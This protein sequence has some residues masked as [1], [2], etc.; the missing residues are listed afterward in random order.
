MS[1]EGDRQEPTGAAESGHAN[2]A[3]V[4]VEA[5]ESV[6]ADDPFDETAAVAR[7]GQAGALPRV[8]LAV[9]LKVAVVN[10]DVALS[11][12]NAAKG[13]NLGHCDGEGDGPDFSG[14]SGRSDR[15]DVES[16]L[17]FARHTGLTR[18]MIRAWETSLSYWCSLR[19]SS[20][21]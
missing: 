6:R 3:A 5:L 15:E 21:L 9:T 1:D 14:R 18:A 10:R 20:W 19:P 2:G 8:V 11:V 13:R 12:R 17:P 7:Q 16:D 4:D